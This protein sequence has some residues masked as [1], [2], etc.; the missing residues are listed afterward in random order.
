MTKNEIIEAINSTIIPNGQ[1]GITAEALA[2]ILIEIT[3]GSGGGTGDVVYAGTADAATGALTQTDEQKLHNAEVFQLVKNSESPVS[4]FMD[5]SD[6]FAQT[7]GFTAKMHNAATL[8]AYIPQE[9]ASVVGFPNETVMIGGYD[10]G[11]DYM[12]SPD[13]TV[14]FMP[15]E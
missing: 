10:L 12:L 1:K 4:L 2:N 11:G 3:N 6:S 15:A 5:M 14:E 9:S 13:G 7:S 8:I